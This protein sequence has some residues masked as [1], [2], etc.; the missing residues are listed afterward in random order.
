MGAIDKVNGIVNHFNAVC[1]SDLNPPGLSMLDFATDHVIG[2]CPL[3]KVIPGSDHLDSTNPGDDL[4]TSHGYG[5]GEVVHIYAVGII[6]GN[7][8][9]F[10]V[11]N[12]QMGRMARHVNGRTDTTLYNIPFDPG[13]GGGGAGGIGEDD[14]VPHHRSNGCSGSRSDDLVRNNN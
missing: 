5:I 14:P 2:N 12:D 4:I 7:P 3:N 9:N 8:F 11:S 1:G 13:M 6:R 10:V